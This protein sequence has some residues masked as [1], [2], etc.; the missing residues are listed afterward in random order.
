MSAEVRFIS[1]TQTAENRKMAPAVRRMRMAMT[2]S[3][4][5][6]IREAFDSLVRQGYGQGYITFDQI[7]SILPDSAGASEI[8][9][10][11]RSMEELGIRV[12]DSSELLSG[13]VLQGLEQGYLSYSQIAETLTGCISSPGQL[14]DVADLIRNFGISVC[15][16][17]PAP[18]G[19]LICDTETAAADCSAHEIQRIV[20][21]SGVLEQGHTTDPLRLYIREA[22][23]IPLLS[24]SKEIELARRIEE[25]TLMV[26]TAVAGYPQAISHLLGIYDEF[27][28][29]RG[30]LGDIVSEFTDMNGGEI[31]LSDE[32]RAKPEIAAILGNMPS[33]GGETEDGTWDDCSGG[34]DDGPDPELAFV[35][36]SKLRKLS[37]ETWDS[38]Q[39]YGRRSQCAEMRIRRLGEFFCQFRLARPQFEYLSG[40]VRGIVGRIDIQEKLILDCCVS[41]C[42]MTREDFNRY[43]RPGMDSHTPG[44]CGG[45]DS[46]IDAAIESGEPFADG[47]RKHRR[48]LERAADRLSGIENEA[49]ISVCD[50]RNISVAMNRGESIARR[51]RE[52]MTR[53][54]LRLVISIAKRYANRGLPLPDL[55]QEGN[56]GLMR[57]V[58]RFEYRRGYKFSTYATWLIRQAIIHS[59]ANQARTIRIPA[60]IAD[61]INRMSHVSE[62][63]MEENGHAPTSGELAQRMGITA[64]RIRQIMRIAQEPVSIDSPAGDDEDSCIG[65]FIVDCSSLRPEEAADAASLR[66][67]VNE[68]LG[69]LSQR[70]EKVLRYRFGI[71]TDRDYTLEELGRAFGVY[72][73]QIRQIEAGAI[74]KLW[75]PSRSRRL[76][77]FADDTEYCCADSNE[78]AILTFPGP[79][80]VNLSDDA[81][82]M[83]LYSADIPHGYFPQARQGLRSGS[84]GDAAVQE[85]IGELLEKGAGV[86]QNYLLAA[87]WYLRSAEHGN[88]CAQFRLGSLYEHGYGLRQDYPEAVR[89]YRMAA[90]RG[91][92]DAEARLREIETVA[93][94]NVQGL[95]G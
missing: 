20:L 89:W 81:D 33:A 10:F 41:K 71:G 46:W 48:E 17:C 18:G 34:D 75:H 58:D 27:L 87:R 61:V 91:S 16:E 80:N 84:G 30:S 14:E 53:A 28:R 66:E 42:G 62:R 6:D 51:A 23:K 11:L 26:Q 55:I 77:S 39:K 90:E 22:G 95:S 68:A 36:F 37:Y 1:G 35:M 7:A 52:E 25:G 56:I 92:A 13:L 60:N 82:R 69:S 64:E 45:N 94:R 57:A 38:I 63:V 65:D 43:C 88:A 3:S 86:E 59:I 4:Q 85:H 24:R 32:D 93:S 67:C 49:G 70:E 12:C 5:S 9:C 73:Q 79:G 72:G 21:E 47:L 78:L 76:R 31:V 83:C 2:D 74:R 8:F 29:G 54:N 40:S 44:S 15:G 19:Q 50:I